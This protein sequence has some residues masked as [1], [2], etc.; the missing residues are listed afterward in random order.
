M[1]L[2][3]AAFYGV[4]DD[5]QVKVNTPFGQTVVLATQNA[6]K[7]EVKG[8]EAQT[9]WVPTDRLTLNLAL[10]LLHT[11]YTDTGG[12]VGLTRNTPFPFSPK[13]TYN[14]GGQYRFS[15]KDAD[16]TLRGDYTYNSRAE[17]NI[18]PV[19]TVS[20]PGYGLLNARLTYQKLDANWN[21]AIFATNL[22]NQFYLTNALNITQEG[23]ALGDA[24]RPRE[25]GITFS[26]KF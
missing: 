19:F 12:T 14:V 13:T 16:L 11:A 1:R 25:L 24:G 22:T 6:G 8:L 2:N 15:V 21:A 3:V 26:M 7:G 17:T 20:Q 18:D 9:T 5:V 23:W 4:Y 10:G